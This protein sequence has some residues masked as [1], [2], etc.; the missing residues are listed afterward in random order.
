MITLIAITALFG[1]T[2]SAPSVDWKTALREDARNVLGTERIVRT[3][4]PFNAGEKSTEIEYYGRLMSEIVRTTASAK[5]LRN[6][7]D[8]AGAALEY[9]GLLQKFPNTESTRLDLF[10]IYAEAG[11]WRKAYI[12]LAPELDRSSSPKSIY[13]ASL[14]TALMG[15]VFEGQRDFLFSEIRGDNEP[16][17]IDFVNAIPK[18]SSAREVVLLSLLAIVVDEFAHG[19]LREETLEIY[20]KYAAGI[21]WGN[22]IIAYCLGHTYVRRDRMIEAEIYLAPAVERA[23]GMLKEEIVELLI[24]ARGG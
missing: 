12:V 18:G 10:D 14:A 11:E 13:R 4:N 3:K 9:I 15:K 16:S 7:G 23:T 6:K 2:Q 5:R 8:L 19:E 22:P 21:D 17:Q 20:A 1:V 24:R